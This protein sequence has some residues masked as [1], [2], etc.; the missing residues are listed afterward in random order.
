[1][2]L[3]SGN[4]ILGWRCSQSE[5][6]YH[7]SLDD[8]VDLSQRRGRTLPLENIE[9]VAV[10]RLRLTRIRVALLKGLGNSLSNRA[11][12]SSH[13]GSAKRDHHV[14]RHA[15]DSLSVLIDLRMIMPFLSVLLLCFHRVRHT[16]MASVHWHQ[17]A[18]LKF[19][20]AQP[21]YQITIS[22]CASRSE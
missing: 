19:P 3:Y 4:S 8:E 10:I 6:T 21:W 15:D 16:S 20:D 12:P 7:G 11:S 22:L 14:S 18:G 1:M 9:I 2:G 5:S 17:Y 13:Q